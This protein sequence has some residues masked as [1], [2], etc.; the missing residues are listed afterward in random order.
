[1]FFDLWLTCR[2]RSKSETQRYAAVNS[3]TQE[4]LCRRRAERVPLPYEVQLTADGRTVR[5]VIRDASLDEAKEWGSIGIS[6][7]HGE[8]LPLRQDLLCRVMSETR[9][10]QNQSV[11]TLMWTRS[12]GTDGFLSGGRMAPLA[13]TASVSPAPGSDDSARGKKP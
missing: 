3:D 10:L 7:L 4:M 2:H 5:A 6:L 9:I 13:S 11:V 8:C 12:F 1:M